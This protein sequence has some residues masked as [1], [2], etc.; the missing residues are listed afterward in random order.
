MRILF[1]SHTRLGDAVIS[2]GLLG[3]LLDIYPDAK[4]T[5]ACGPVAA[6]VFGS[7]PALERL[8]IMRKG[9]YAAHWRT[10]LAAC[11]PTFW[12]LI[13]DLRG[14]ASAWILPCKRRRI[15][16]GGNGVGHRVEQLAR[17]FKLKE[18]PG[19]RIWTS[20]EDRAAAK[21]L[22]GADPRPILALAPT[23]NW[24]AKTWPVERFAETA[25]QLTGAGGALEGAWLAVLSAPS[26]REEA[27]P[28]LE[29]GPEGNLIDLAG[30]RPLG[31]IA[32]LL[33]RSALFIGNDS[34]L[35][36]L[37]AASGAP[38]LGLFGPSKDEHYRPWG[39]HT[40]FVR[41]D[42]DYDTLKQDPL[43]CRA[44][45]RSLMEDLPVSRV[46]DAAGRLLA[47]K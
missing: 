23:A 40:A 30:T 24:R 12:D 8:V 9:P 20:E 3:Y 17:L 14:S 45:E 2:T 29:L 6:P 38:T 18:V 36:H 15:F 4:F 16:S 21:A 35:M 1:I 11:F 13:V 10:L 32:A 34:G 46:L 39:A 25:R 27:A 37:A 7:F 47:G 43:F 44:P 33:A 5:I 41:T 28:L 26:E 31:T 22:I 42:R 19:P